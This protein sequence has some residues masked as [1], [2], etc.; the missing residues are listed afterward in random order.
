MYEVQETNLGFAV[1]NA[2]AVHSEHSRKADADRIV[3]ELN[4]D[5]AAYRWASEEQGFDGTYADWCDLDAD[6]RSEYEA[7]A[8]GIPT[9]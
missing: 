1:V 4:A 2:G 7:G 6:E 5:H 3:R 9:A 8:A